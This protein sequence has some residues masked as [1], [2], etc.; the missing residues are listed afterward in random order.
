MTGKF[1]VDDQRHYLFSPRHLTQWVFG[2]LRYDLSSGDVL[3]PWMYEARRLFRD[4]LVEQDVEKFD[5]L[6]A[7]VVRSD[8]NTSPGMQLVFGSIYLASSCQNLR[9]STSLLLDPA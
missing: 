4:V 9:I 5:S 1:T 3:T 8:W 7:N 2:L 6:L